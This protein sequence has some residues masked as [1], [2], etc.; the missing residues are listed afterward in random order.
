MLSCEMMALH[1]VYVMSMSVARKTIM[2]G[3][4]HAC[5]DSDRQ[6]HSAWAKV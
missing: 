2:Y 6:T 4:N 3:V 5:R 1:S